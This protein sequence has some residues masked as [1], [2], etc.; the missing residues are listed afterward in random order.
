MYILPGAKPPCPDPP[1]MLGLVPRKV[2]PSSPFGKRLV[3]L[4]LERGLTQADLAE[5]IGSNQRNVS[6]YE[7]VAE[8]PPTDVLVKLASVLKVSTDEL[9]GLKTPKKAPE[10]KED[11]EER[12]LWKKFQAVRSLPEKDQRA[13]IRLVN[14]LVSAKELRRGSGLARSA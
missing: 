14:S 4:R 11:P 8:F 12:R 2:T 3:Q 5:L 10:P 6:H 1:P 13:V 7:T 9:L